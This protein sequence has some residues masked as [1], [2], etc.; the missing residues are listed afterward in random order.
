[1]FGLTG[2]DASLEKFEVYQ[3]ASRLVKPNSLSFYVSIFVCIGV[4]KDR[5]SQL[6]S[7]GNL[8]SFSNKLD[9]E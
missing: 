7:N 1:M 4:F 6:N 5:F 3:L 2:L 9:I 8:L